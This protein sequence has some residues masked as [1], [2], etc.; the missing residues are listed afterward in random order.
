M[1]EGEDAPIGSR[2][3]PDGLGDR[4]LLGVL[5]SLIE[6]WGG[7]AL[8]LAV[9]FLLARLLDAEAF[10]LVALSMATI[11]FMQLLV[12]MG[13]AQ[14]LVQRE[15][16]E[17][18]HTDA[19]FWANQ[20]VGVALALLVLAGARPL[21]A[22]LGQP[23]LAPVLRVLSALFVIGALGSVPRALLER[24]LQFRALA[25]RSLV[26]IALGGIVGVTMAFAGFGLWS[27]VGQHLV[28]E[29]VG[30]ALIWRA[31]AWRPRLRFSWRHWR[32][33]A[34]FGIHVFGLEV[35][36]YVKDESHPL[37]IGLFLTPVAL[38]FYT[39]AEQLTD[40]LAYLLIAATAPVALPVFSR[41]QSDLGRFRDVF[42]RATR[43]AAAVAVPVFVAV[44]A[45]APVIVAF[46][47]GAKWQ[48]AGPLLRVLAI[49]GIVD[50]L[51]LFR[52]PVLTAMGKPSWRLYQALLSATLHAVFFAIAYRYGIVAVAWAYLARR[53]ILLPIGQ[54]SVWLLIR[55]SWRTY[56]GGLAGPLLGAAALLPAVL[57][58]R[59]LLEASGAPV[60]VTLAA[61]AGAGFATYLAVMLVCAP[62]L[63]REGWALAGRFRQIAR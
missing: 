61:S 41:L 17:P 52:G 39:L 7:K 3:A 60:L 33:L 54:A 26:G 57:G 18:E 58:A 36:N 44:A 12:D 51:T 2:R 48:E 10:G 53:L 50:V 28:F 46:L 40:A 25:L 14:A 59:S 11:A 21:A 19:A 32:E 43:I 56:L 16:L 55:F 20:I 4:T 62:G 37:L 30:L 15:D 47:F 27:L 8:A 38:G 13:F 22:L 45:L 31:S 1:P 23:E 35:V 63:V 49:A 34:G 24:D 6:A 29:G 42:Y 9:V 5:W